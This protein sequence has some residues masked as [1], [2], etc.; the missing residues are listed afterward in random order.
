MPSFF[1]ERT[2]EYALVPALQS[3][4]QSVFKFATPIFFW[5]T[6]EG[7]RVSENQHLHGHV[8][9][10]AV[11]ARRPKLQ[12]DTGKVYGKIN[13]DLVTYAEKSS[14][15]G[16]PAI[17]GFPVVESL[18]DLHSQASMLWFS[19]HG[20]PRK[21]IEFSVALQARPHLTEDLDGAL[22]QPLELTD[23]AANITRSRVFS[24]Q[25]AMTQLSELRID[26]ADGYRSRVNWF[27][28]SYKPVYF[29]VSPHMR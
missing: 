27:G 28:S 10:L 1:C 20:L 25:D 2:A 11:F 5:K 4:L 9:L 16:V 17:A 24:W 19:L 8:H 22:L 29:L 3:H 26:Q 14:L 6:R 13:Q 12:S 23:I 7:N 21:D 18:F 15:A